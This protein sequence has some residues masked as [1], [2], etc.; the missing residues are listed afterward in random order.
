M[1]KNMQCGMIPLPVLSELQS[2]QETF[3]FEKD[4]KT[5]N[6]KFVTINEQLTTAEQR[7][8]AVDRIIREFREK[9][10]FAT[11]NGWRDEVRQF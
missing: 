4:E 8:Q 6:I 2:N 1:I 3:Q 10:L 9:K 5:G 7:T 11:L